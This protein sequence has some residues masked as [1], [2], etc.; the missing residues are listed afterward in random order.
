MIYNGDGRGEGQ[1]GTKHVFKSFDR[2][3]FRARAC[4]RALITFIAIQ[5]NEVKW[6]K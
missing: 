5:I 2:I 6:L 3:R 1:M 4:A